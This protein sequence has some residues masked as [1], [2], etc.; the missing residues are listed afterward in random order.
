MPIRIT[1]VGDKC[2]GKTQFVNCL[3]HL[4]PTP[5]LATFD[6][7]FSKHLIND[8]E[9]QVLDTP[10]FVPHFMNSAQLWKSSDAFLLF[11]DARQPVCHLQEWVDLIRSVTQKG[12]LFLLQT[13]IDERNAK[14]ICIQSKQCIYLGALSL[15][16]SPNV[17]SI[18]RHMI[19]KCKS[20]SNKWF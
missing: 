14:P 17:D 3:S 7:Q 10:G 9:V 11:H 5:T 20:H 15:S 1:L 13:S 2:S 16:A 18:V 19:S 12:V 8:Q 6:L 4:P